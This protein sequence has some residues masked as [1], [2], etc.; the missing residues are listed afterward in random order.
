MQ[1]V[2]I[3]N[4]VY[5]SAHLPLYPNDCNERT[6]WIVCKVEG[7]G[8]SEDTMLTVTRAYNSFLS[9]KRLPISDFAYCIDPEVRYKDNILLGHTYN[10]NQQAV[11]LGFY[12]DMVLCFNTETETLEYKHANE[13]WTKHYETF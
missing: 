9:T 7:D 11:A 5:L 6:E 10:E 2:D 4:R 3:G 1:Q 13:L 8:K 12:E